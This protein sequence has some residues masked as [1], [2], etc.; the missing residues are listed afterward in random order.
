MTQETSSV[1][2]K[3]TG[4]TLTS[5]ELNEINGTVN[6]NA[7][8]SESR[9][10]TLESGQSG[11][12]QGWGYY[13]DN[14]A[15][16]VIGLTDTK[17]TIDGL[18]STSNLSY[19]PSGVANLWDT[20][21]NKVISTGVGDSYTLRLDLP[22]TDKGNNADYIRFKMDIGSGATP[23]IIVVERIIGLPDVS[24]LPTTVSVSF[25]YF[26]LSTF[27]ANNAQFFLSTNSQTVTV[28]N[29]AVAIF[30]TTGAVL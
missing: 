4:D 3:V 29:P 23:S 22:I 6:A 19:L 9:L 15:S 13:K 12:A 30:R 11:T 17:L 5:S 7:A 8:D 21:T 2:S 1:P 24:E 25:S 16:Q 27:D 20:V 14:A 28:T 18:G 26:S 10:V